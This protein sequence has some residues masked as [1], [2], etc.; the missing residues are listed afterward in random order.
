ME[1]SL[2]EALLF[3]KEISYGVNG[4]ELSGTTTFVTDGD[5]S[6]GFTLEIGSSDSTT[7]SLLA[8]HFDTPQTV[9]AHQLHFENGLP[10]IM[11]YDEDENVI[12]TE[13][14]LIPN[15]E[16][17]QVLPQPVTGVSSIYLSNR[18]TATE[19]CRVIA[20]DLYR[21]EVIPDSKLSLLLEQE[22]TAQLSLTNQ[23]G[24][25]THFDWSSQDESICTVDERGILTAVSEGRT[26]VK[27]QHKYSDY[28]DVIFIKVVGIGEA[29]QYRLAIHLLTNQSENLHYNDEREVT[30]LSM[31]PNVAIVDSTGRVSGLSKGLALI[32]AVCDGETE[33]IYV[34]VNE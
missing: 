2:F 30:W 13:L 16:E 26:L 8:Y 23:L 11:M 18:T 10:M 24:D 5:P 33:T 32:Q 22:E 12:F 19:P 20:W 25:N 28:E 34:R 14:N 17:I 9:H 4:N 29:E 6:T 1:N 15:Q 3:G 7:I 31:D 27:A 21:E